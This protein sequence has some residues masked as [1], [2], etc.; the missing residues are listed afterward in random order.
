MTAEDLGMRR[1]GNLGSLSMIYEQQ[2]NLRLEQP[3][4]VHDYL[5]SGM[6]LSMS[7]YVSSDYWQNQ[8]ETYI[9]SSDWQ[10]RDTKN[11]TCSPV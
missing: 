3:T 2:R 8:M 7:E 9:Q 4:D 11:Y 10:L 5:P 6:M 1:V